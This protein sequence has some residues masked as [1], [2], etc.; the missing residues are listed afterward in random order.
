MVNIDITPASLNYHAL[1]PKSYKQN[2]CAF[3][4]MFHFEFGSIVDFVDNR[5]QQICYQ[6]PLSFFFSDS[7]Y[8]MSCPENLKTVAGQVREARYLVR[9]L[10]GLSR[11]LSTM[12]R[13]IHWCWSVVPGPSM[14]SVRGQCDRNMIGRVDLE[15]NERHGLTYF[16]NG[17]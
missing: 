16:I 13:S 2:Y 15:W 9:M 7:Q 5:F 10:R 3:F 1:A 11:V 14:T 12:R 4:H 17:Y 8:T 6:S